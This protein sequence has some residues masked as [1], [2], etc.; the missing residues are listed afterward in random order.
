M[1]EKNA[2]VK[3]LVTSDM[4]HENVY[5]PFKNVQTNSRIRP[6]III[7]ATAFR[8]SGQVSNSDDVTDFHINY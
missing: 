8:S 4:L 1:Q 5:V 7:G 6:S 3:S 2:L